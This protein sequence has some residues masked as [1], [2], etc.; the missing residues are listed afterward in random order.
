MYAREK[1]LPEQQ[2]PALWKPAY[3]KPHSLPTAYAEKANSHCKKQKKQ[4]QV[5]A[6]SQ[7]MLNFAAK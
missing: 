5:L 3:D 7:K 1:S 6:K 4:A 2:R